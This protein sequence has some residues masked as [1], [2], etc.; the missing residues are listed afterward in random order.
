MGKELLKLKQKGLKSLKL[1]ND[2][3]YKNFTG[4]MDID[5]S[6]IEEIKNTAESIKKN[7]DVLVIVGVGGSYL[8]ARAV[9]E[10][11]T[12]KY[13]KEIE[14]VYMGESLSPLDIKETL[15][16]LETKD[17]TVNVISKSGTTLEPALAFSLLKNLLFKKYDKQE[18]LNRIVVTTDETKGLLREFVTENN[19]KSFVIPEDVGGRFSVLTPV[20]LLPI[21]VAGIDIKALLDGAFHA[22]KIH[23]EETLENAA[24]EYAAMRNLY[25]KAGY[26]IEIL[27]TYEPRLKYFTAW[28]KQLFGESEGK[29]GKGIFP[30][31]AVYTTDLH[32][33]GQLIQEGE[34]NLMETHIS[35]LN[36]QN[37]LVIN[38]DEKGLQNLN[39]KTVG[40]IN[41][42]AYIA[43][44]N[45]HVDGDVPVF[46]MELEKLDEFNIGKL[47]HF[48]M[49]ACS[50]S[51]LI[52]GV[53]PFDQ[54][55]VEEYKKNMK[56]L[57]YK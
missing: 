4:W 7:S 52:L 31:T 43:T 40:Y 5:Y 17:F 29:E 50:I 27:A 12:N 24:I 15:E 28:W 30:S 46:R 51:A 14:I 20:G 53:N 49:I 57:L 45:A 39:G 22:N 26:E 54:P 48:F 1:L 13:K 16:Y 2:N 32:S 9:I 41:K 36:Y 11:L 21:A 47:I 42:Q 3:G 44:A 23:T 18:A 35:I 19:V 56:E 55:G 6:Q 33:M 8:G 25:Y 37:D 34:R 10:A 38:T